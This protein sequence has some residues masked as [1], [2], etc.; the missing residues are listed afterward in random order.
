M[1]KIPRNCGECG[2]EFL[3]WPHLIK[4]GKSH[5]CSAECR[6]KRA[7]DKLR[8][9]KRENVIVDMG[10]HSEIVIGQSRILID[11]QDVDLINKYTWGVVTNG[12]VYTQRRV[13]GGRKIRIS[14]HRFLIGTPEGMDTDHINNNRLDNRR[15][16]LRICT[17]SQ[18]LMNR[19]KLNGSNPYKG[20]DKTKNGK[21]FSARIQGKRIGTFQTA[22]EAAMAYNNRAK[23]LFRDFAKLNLLPL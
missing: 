6:K 3:A 12:Y 16:N 7:G 19:G 2:K 17:T 9:R 21:R 18:N 14:L 22:E 4:I 10:T 11:S 8:F 5:F 1:G 15:S 23:E 13:G 20:V